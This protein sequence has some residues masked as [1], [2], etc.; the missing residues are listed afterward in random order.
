MKEK[1]IAEECIYGVV[2]KFEAKYG[3]HHWDDY[4]VVL[5]HIAPYMA[6]RP[7]M[8]KLI[9]GDTT[10]SED[11][12]SQTYSSLIASL[13]LQ[14]KPQIAF[15]IIEAL[16]KNKKLV[17]ITIGDLL[18]KAV[19]LIER[20]YDDSDIEEDSDFN[21]VYK[22]TPEVKE[23]LLSGTEM[24]KREKEKADCIITILSIQALS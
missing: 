12:S 9:F 10:I 5:K 13:L 24:I 15:C 4:G 20:T 3:G 14:N 23:A 7:E 1:N 11:Y 22:I 6:K 2:S 17:N 8:I 16:I 21:N 18:R 19:E